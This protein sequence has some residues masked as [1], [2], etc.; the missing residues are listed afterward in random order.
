MGHLEMFRTVCGEDETM[1]HH[2]E[3][4]NSCLQCS[5]QI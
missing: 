3:N 1:V 4:W 5:L 2:A